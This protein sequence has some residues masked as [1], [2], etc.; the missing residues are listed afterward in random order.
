MCILTFLQ[1]GITPDLDALEGG[2]AANPHGHGYAVITDDRILVG[3]GLDPQAMISEFAAVRANYPAGAALFHSRLATHGLIDP[4]NCHPFALGGDER[5]VMAHNGI[6][7]I[8]VHPVE[9]DLRSDTRI[10]A[11]DFLPTRPF[12][13][14]DSPPGR[15]RLERWLGHDKMVLLSIDPAYM[16]RAYLF[17]ERYGYWTDKGI[18]YSN[19]SYRTAPGT[20]A[21]YF[22]DTLRDR[23]S[24]LNCGEQDPGR[25]GSHCTH[26]GFCAACW[27][28]RF[29]HCEC[30]D[31]YRRDRYADLDN[32]LTT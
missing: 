9:G 18:W 17:N 22:D 19:L 15:D 28:R 7:P 16:H 31:L 13:S 6:L 21:T 32:Y 2:A 14:L 4:A 1:P 10:A 25:V 20:I 11:E 23:L 29:P 24:C 8:T 26:C 30:R 5:T 12:G 27:L 3:R